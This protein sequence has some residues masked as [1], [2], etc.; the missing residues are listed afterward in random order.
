MSDFPGRAPPG[1][2]R[3]AATAGRAN[4]TPAR[5]IGRAGSPAGPGTTRSPPHR[6][7][8]SRKSSMM[9][10]SEDGSSRTRMSLES[11]SHLDDRARPWSETRG[12]AGLRDDLVH[13]LGPEDLAGEPAAGA[14]GGDRARIRWSGCARSSRSITSI[15]ESGWPRCRRYRSRGSPPESTTAVLTLTEPTSMPTYRGPLGGCDGTSSSPL[16]LRVRLGPFA[17]SLVEAPRPVPLEVDGDRGES[18]RPERTRRR[19]ARA[20]GRQT[21]RPAPGRPRSARRAVGA[22]ADPPEAFG[23]QQFLGPFHAAQAPPARSAGRREEEMRDAGR[24]GRRLR[25][26]PGSPEPARAGGHPPG[27]SRVPER[28]R[29]A[30]LPRARRP[31]AGAVV[32]TGSRPAG[33]RARPP[34]SLPRG[35]GPQRAE[36][37]VCT[38][39]SGRRG[40]P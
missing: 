8:S 40:S 17:P 31:F 34:R 33:T 5:S 36:K 30:H 1:D 19:E 10:R 24:A 39:S 11:S 35:D 27:E 32:P 29:G 13:E 23:P 6:P 38:S 37:R 7:C 25:S 26:Q 4:R 14:G 2:A 9:P 3:G 18:G 22:H 20:A 28:A 16:P 15:T 12:G 21:R